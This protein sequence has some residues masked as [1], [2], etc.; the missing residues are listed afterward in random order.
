[1]IQVATPLKMSKIRAGMR[2]LQK[3]RALTHQH[4]KKHM[5][6]QNTHS[7]CPNNL[8]SQSYYVQ[9]LAFRMHERLSNCTVTTATSGW[10]ASKKTPKDGSWYRLTRACGM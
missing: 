5:T 8:K 3:Y 2:T 7:S 4:R 1:M 6:L 10:H 9:Q